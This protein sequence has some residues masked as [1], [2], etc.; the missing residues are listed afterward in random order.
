MYVY[1]YV[2]IYMCVCMCVCMYIYVS[3]YVCV[4]AHV[5]LYNGGESASTIYHML[6]NRIPSAWHALHLFELLVNAIP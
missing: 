1:I 5:S 4:C 6:P 2:C 3:I